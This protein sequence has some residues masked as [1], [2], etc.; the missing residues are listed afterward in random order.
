MSRPAALQCRKHPYYGA[1]QKPRSDC[2]ACR[3]IWDSKHVPTM[4]RV[5]EVLESDLARPR[6]R[7][8]WT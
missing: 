8:I 7:E 4:W 6:R 2:V 3:I 5:I 1:R